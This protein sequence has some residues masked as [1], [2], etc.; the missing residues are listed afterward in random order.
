[1][2][3]LTIAAVV[4]AAALGAARCG[5]DSDNPTGPSNTGPVVFT[6]QLSAANEVPPITNAESGGR[7]TATVTMNVPRDNSGVPTGPGTMNW[8]V[9]LTGLPPNTAIILGHI[10]TGAAGVNGGVLVN[11]GLSAAAPVLAADGSANLSFTSIDV[12]ATNALNI[13]NNP[14]GFYV[15]FHTPTNPGGVVRG[16]LTRVQ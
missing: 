12:N 16:Q 10:H 1:M 7:G 6:A 13:Y 3:R 11:T 4:V 5:G 8:S 15:N 14:A 9:Q 2:R